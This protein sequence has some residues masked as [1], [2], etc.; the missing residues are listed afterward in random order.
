MKML[1]FN[2][3]RKRQ[4]SLIA[5]FILVNVL[6]FSAIAGIVIVNLIVSGK[7]GN[8][9][10]AVIEHD[11][12]RMIRNATISR[13]L[14]KIFSDSQLFIATFLDEH[15]ARDTDGAQLRNALQRTLASV[16]QQT[17]PTLYATLE[18]FVT[19]LQT[20]LQQAESIRA[21][22]DALHQINLDLTQQ[23][24]LLEETVTD[25]IVTMTIEKRE[26]ES[27]TI[28]QIGVAIPEYQKMLLEIANHL[29]NSTRASLTAD[30]AGT[31]YAERIA[32]ILNEL[33][34]GLIAITTAGDQ[35]AP[36]GKQMLALTAQYQAQN[37]QFHQAMQL[38]HEELQALGAAKNATMEL[39]AGIEST[40]EQTTEIVSQEIKTNIRD[41]QRLTLALTIIVIA[42]M[43]GLGWSAVKM[44]RPVKPLARLA[45]QLAQGNIAAEMNL[46]QPSNASDEISLLANAF[47]DLI[48]YNRDVAGIASEIAQG[49]LTCNFQP[50]SDQDMLGH[51]FVEMA[52]YL[53][54]IA[55]IAAAIASGDLSCTIQPKTDRD[56][57][58]QAF[59]KMKTLRESMRKIMQDATQLKNASQNLYRISE[60]MVASIQQA[61]QQ[62]ASVSLNSQQISE[63]VG[64]VA[65]V[66]EEM[67]ASISEMSK[68]T[69]DV[70]QIAGT[71]V[72]RAKSANTIIA[73]LAVQSQRIGDIITVITSVSQQT[74]LLALNATIEAARAGDFGRGFAVVA[75]EIKQLSRETA[76]SAKDIIHKLERIQTGSASATEAITEVLDINT[77]INA[78][79]SMTASG[80]EQQSAVTG[81]IAARMHET[82]AGS[83]D[84][85][86]VIADVASSFQETS[87]G[88]VGVQSAAQELASLADELQQL[89]GMFKI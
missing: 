70:A 82:A 68:N 51:A 43:A 75:H 69:A 62:T 33:K 37:T 74:N 65:S 22:S 63:N 11:M 55:E 58:G 72:Q 28:E 85:T 49:N 66:I 77:Q 19:H 8:K 10:I 16:D 18:D 78:I 64:T 26:D 13:D 76:L 81:E 21:A 53:K 32:T 45:V 5:K 87:N 89:V 30:Y 36:L 29:S 59:A 6:I 4:S 80:V 31:Q 84:I 67:S 3:G 83:A 38:F 71:A 46:L 73:D 40:I 52:A 24:T 47:H 54:T 20:I 17:N 7:I 39:L 42:I 25:L 57:L 88:A 44:L 15:E 9:L 12:A 34:S 23:I 61:S 41:S 60:Q 48:A 14:N 27:V 1:P 35:L 56:V 86:K 50:R 2:L 79:A